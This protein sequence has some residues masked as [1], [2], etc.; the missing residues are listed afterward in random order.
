VE[1]RHDRITAIKVLAQLDREALLL[2][3]WCDLTNTMR[4][5]SWSR[6]SPRSTCVCTGRADVF[7][8]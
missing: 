5:G 3:T 7:N 8:E 1:R 4:P 6:Q 2:V